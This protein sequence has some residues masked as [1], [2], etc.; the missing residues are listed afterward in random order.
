MNTFIL[1]DRLSGYRIHL[2]GAKGT[3]MCALAEILQASGS[4]VSGSDVSDTFYTDRIL[5][6]LGVV[7][8]DFNPANIHEAIELV[9]HSA[10]YRADTHPELV[11]AK[12]L[13]IPIATYPEALGALSRTMDSSGIC[14][15]HGKTTTTALTGVLARACGLPATILAGSAVSDFGDR[16]T[17]ILGKDLFIAET[18]EYRRHFLS[19]S[20]K[21]IVLTS[22]EPDHQDYYPDYDSIMDAFLE[23]TQLLPEGG[24]LIYCSDDRGASDLAS[25]LYGHRPDI[26]A[27]AYGFSAPGRFHITDYLVHN[28]RARF[29]LAGYSIP[30]SLRLPGR[31]LALD[32]TAALALCH[33]VAD[34]LD[35]PLDSADLVAMASAIDGFAGSRRR[36]ELIGEARG[37]LVMDDYA[38]HPTA[39]RT[40]LAGL[41]EFYPQR[42]L[43]VDFM[44]HTASRTKALF[45]D[46]A[47]AFD[48]AD[49]TVLHR[50][51][52]SAR[53]APDPSVSGRK[54][55]QAILASGVPAT[56]FENPLEAADYLV[57]TLRPGDLFITMG[58]GDNWQLGRVVHD[59]LKADGTSDTKDHA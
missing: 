41:R 39:I 51:Y 24:T 4:I 17:L 15:V 32:A 44:S 5:S 35:R 38:H 27:I 22:V 1:P 12:K 54:L 56:Y 58:A 57:A 30:F 7:V 14:G 48:M 40:T 33:T 53:E 45:D 34:D 29:H 23:Y 26:S 50:I 11:Q 25:R 19:F 13:G 46:F 2:V 47:A 37:V 28:E 20:P 9:V 3:G 59:R 52:P 21:R 43:V 31:H 6:A 55:F 49:E 18:C 16:S 36:S 42:R 8:K 10:A